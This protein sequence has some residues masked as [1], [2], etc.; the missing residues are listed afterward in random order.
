MLVVLASR[1][2]LWPFNSVSGIE[3]ENSF[4]QRIAQRADFLLVA[5]Q[6]FARQFRGLAHADNQRH[7]LSPATQTPLLMPAVDER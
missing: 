1:C 7:A 3:L 6:V 4:L 5:R 2:V